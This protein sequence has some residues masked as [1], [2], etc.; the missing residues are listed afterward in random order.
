MPR[1]G[2]TMAA[3]AAL[4]ACAGTAR[5]APMPADIVGNW[6]PAPDCGP[7]APR[8][9]FDSS[10]V[11]IVQGDGRKKSVEVETAGQAGDRLEIRVTKVVTGE[12]EDP[13]GTHVGDTIVVRREN[14]ELHLLAR[15]DNGGPP[16][17]VQNAPPL[18]RC[19]P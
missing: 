12:A 19:K 14:D 17:E 4:L 6:S 5:A 11:S 15:S 2:T 1:R 10:T 9:V 18:H 16:V 8:M 3:L 7:A 13:A